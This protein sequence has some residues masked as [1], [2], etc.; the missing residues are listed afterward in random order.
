MKGNGTSRR[1]RQLPTNGDPLRFVKEDQLR[2]LII[3]LDEV[4][5]DLMGR[6]LGGDNGAFALAQAVKAAGNYLAEQRLNAQ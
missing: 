5:S 6:A 4:Y 3:D 1:R 2:G